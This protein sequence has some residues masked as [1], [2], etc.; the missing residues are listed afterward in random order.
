VLGEFLKFIQ[1]GNVL[2]LAVAVIVGGAFGRITTSLVNDIIMP[3]I[4]LLI[5]G[6]DFSALGV[7]LAPDGTYASVPEAIAA[8]APV[9]AIGAFLNTLINFII[10]ALVIFL[11]LRGGARLSSRFESSKPT[12]PAVPAPLPADV[13]LLTEIRDL[14]K[15]Q[16]TASC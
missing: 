3:P 9:I 8:G 6:V 7:V 1:R 12:T 15:R 5:G 2:D 14:L 10:I 4:G 11:V 16:E 13:Q